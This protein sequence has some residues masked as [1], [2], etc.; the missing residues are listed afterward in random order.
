MRR[1]FLADEIFAPCSDDRI[2]V[3]VGRW[4]VLIKAVGRPSI[5]QVIPWR[6]RKKPVLS[7]D[8]FP[9]VRQAWLRRFLFHRTGIVFCQCY[10]TIQGANSALKIILN[11]SII[12]RST[13]FFERKGGWHRIYP[14]SR[15]WRFC[16]GPTEKREPSFVRK[17]GFFLS[18]LGLINKASVQLSMKQRQRR[19]SLNL[20]MDV[21]AMPDDSFHCW[22]EVKF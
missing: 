12:S 22:E 10:K 14:L 7:S 9:H 2:H 20:C 5:N 18:R 3:G 16:F 21:S 19:K 6:R 8:P 15:Y 17:V 11:G 13:H 1:H 4:I